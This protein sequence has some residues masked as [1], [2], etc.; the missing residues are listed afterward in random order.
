MFT[1]AL[2]M[3]VPGGSNF[4]GNVPCWHRFNVAV[5]L[6]NSNFVVTAPDGSQTTVALAA[7]LTQDVVIC[8]LPANAFVH[9]VREKTVTAFAGAT[10]TTLKLGVAGADTLFNSS[11]F[12]IMAAPS[13]TNFVPATTAG[14][15]VG[16][17]TVAAIDFVALVTTTVSNISALTAGSVDIWICL[18]LLDSAGTDAT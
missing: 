3:L 15:T 10:T 14:S 7:A 13:A 16:N 12:D 5:D 4:V 2:P 17:N 8:H 1:L 18:A 6:A 9:A 11:A